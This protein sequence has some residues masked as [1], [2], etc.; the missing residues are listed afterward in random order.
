MPNFSRSSANIQAVETA[1]DDPSHQSGLTAAIELAPP[2][3]S[4]E[5]RIMLDRSKLNEW[6]M[7]LTNIAV[8]AGIVFL[9]MEIRQNNELLHS[10]SR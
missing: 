6:L 10:E 1:A 4:S 3:R 7:P 2:G 8:V 5:G 9:A